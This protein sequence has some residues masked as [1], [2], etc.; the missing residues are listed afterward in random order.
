MQS[1]IACPS[2]GHRLRVEVRGDRSNIPC[3]GCGTLL[4]VVNTT[5]GIRL[6]LPPGHVSQVVAVNPAVPLQPASRTPT[7]TP[8]AACPAVRA[9]VPPASRPTAVTPFDLKAVL[10]VRACGVI[11]WGSLIVGVL[12]LLVGVGWKMRNSQPS[13]TAETISSANAAVPV[14]DAKSPEQ[15]P[16]AS[17]AGSPTATQ[18]ATVH[19][20]AASPTVASPQVA[21]PRVALTT[22]ELIQKVEPSI[23][24]IRTRFG[25]GS[26]FV[27]APQLICT[28]E[29]VLETDDEAHWFVEF[30]TRSGLLFRKVS[31]ALALEGVDL[32]LLRVQDLPRDYVPLPVVERSKLQKGERLVVIGSPGGLENVVTEGILGSFQEIEQQTYIQLS[33][34]INPGNSGGPALNEFGEVAGV[35]TLKAEQEGIGMAIPGD[36]V[37]RAVQDL[38]K[39]SPIRLDEQRSRW[40]ARQI[41]TK[42]LRGSREAIVLRAI[43]TAVIEEKRLADWEFQYGDAQTLSKEVRQRSTN[44]QVS[45]LLTKLE[46]LFRNAQLALNIETTDSAALSAILDAINTEANTLEQEI[47]AKLGPLSP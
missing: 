26:G 14:E 21:A 4:T 38:A 22:R 11:G 15:P 8:P 18:T 28:N 27:V 17:P 37:H 24:R 33:V 23:C 13:A 3:Q 29:H 30:P 1:E 12:A 36:E 39:L 20:G 31:L 35:V 25:A 2:C 16:D 44:S 43:G 9:V 34:T 46:Q 10:G 19:T 40:K 7:A 6:L 42:L 47:Q 45:D 41:S 32:V 5:K